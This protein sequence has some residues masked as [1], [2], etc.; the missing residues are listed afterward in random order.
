MPSEAEVEALAAELRVHYG[1]RL[2]S[3]SAARRLLEAAERARRGMDKLDVACAA[4]LRSLWPGMAPWPEISPAERD[5]YRRAM[6][7]AL[8]AI[9]VEL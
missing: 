3:H 7:A 4:Y 1:V 5:I 6:K 9:G 2:N 8:D